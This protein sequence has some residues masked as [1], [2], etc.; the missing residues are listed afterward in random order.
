MIKTVFRHVFR[1]LP[2]VKS[3]SQ[4]VHSRT[5]GWYMVMSEEN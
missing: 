3:V 1:K 5:C 4:R 2:L